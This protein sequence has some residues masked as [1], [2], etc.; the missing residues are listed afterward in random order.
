MDN[1]KNYKNLSFIGFLLAA[2]LLT[3]VVAASSSAEITSLRVA[4]MPYPVHKQQLKWMEKWAAEKGITIERAPIAYEHYAQEVVMHL[5]RK[6]P[7]FDII[8]HNDDWGEMYAKLLEPIDD[9]PDFKKVSPTLYDGVFPDR[10][11]FQPG[12]YRITGL[13]FTTTSAVLFYRKDLAPTAPRTWWEARHSR[14]WT[15]AT[16]WTPCSECTTSWPRPR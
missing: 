14:P 5:T 15:A 3:F 16:P 12:D 7:P 6:D 9:I 1:R 10:I 13:P 4:Y 2:L 11:P 8:W